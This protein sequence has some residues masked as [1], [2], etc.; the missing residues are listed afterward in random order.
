[1]QTGAARCSVL[2][3]LADAIAINRFLAYSSA[4]V[5][6]VRLSD[7]THT[8]Q[9]AQSAGPT[10]SAKWRLEGTDKIRDQLVS[11]TDGLTLYR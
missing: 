7:C 9:D 11:A 6:P 3:G 8:D 1:M 5:Q 4:H 2:S 10:S